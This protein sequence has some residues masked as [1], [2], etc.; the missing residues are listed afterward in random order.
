MARFP[1]QLF[2]PITTREAFDSLRADYEMARVSRYLPAPRGVASMGSGADY[3]YRAE[4]DFLRMIERSRALD[5]NNMVI[6]QAIT[7]LMANIFQD[8]FACDPNTGDADTDSAIRELWTAW[9]TEDATADASQE[10]ALQELA[11]A[12][13]RAFVVDGDSIVLPLSMRAGGGLQLIEAHRVRTPSNTKRPVVHGVLLDDMR[14]H[15]EYWIAPPDLEAW[16]PLRRVGDVRAVATRDAA[17]RRQVLHIRNAKR[18]SQTRGVSMLAP[19]VY[20]AHYHDDIQFAHLVKA[21][22]ASCYVIFRMQDPSGGGYGGPEATGPRGTTTS[23][24]LA[25]GTTRAIEGVSPGM[26]ITGRPGERFEGFTPNI[27]NPEFFE[28]ASL[29]LSIIAVN[30]G[31]P[32]QVLL[33]DATRTNFSGWR[34]AIDQA[35]IGMRRLQR[36]MISKFYT[37]VYRHKLSHFIAA[38]EALR[39]MAGRLDSAA[40]LRHEFHPPAWSYIE[41]NKDALADATIIG[42]RL[43]SRRRVL[44]RRGIEIEDED[45][46]IVSDN[47]RLARAAISEARAINGEYPEAAVDWRELC[48]FAPKKVSGQVGRPAAR[49]VAAGGA[50]SDGATQGRSD[51]GTEEASDA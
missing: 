32:V 43:A 20:P 47:A 13:F 28:H 4:S 10:N 17:G 11:E 50:N 44:A 14:R 30:L 38:S 25:D 9:A 18:V 31:I 46:F 5:R 49:T 41:P 48:H 39:R 27:P 2:A 24:T 21:Q 23:E 3:H 22:L 40:L 7:R 26:E 8:G 34:G 45:R 6:G 36:F 16:Q 29:V 1:G 15:L 33:L 35:R 51:E 19:V 12:A 37:P 42:N